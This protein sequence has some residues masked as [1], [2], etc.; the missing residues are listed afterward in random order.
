MAMT[1]TGV[2][3]VLSVISFSCQLGALRAAAAE[4]HVGAHARELARGLLAHAAAGS[5]DKRHATAEID[6][7]W[8]VGHGTPAPVWRVRRAHDVA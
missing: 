5:S 8:L 1:V 2:A 4:D 6:V 7:E 3:P